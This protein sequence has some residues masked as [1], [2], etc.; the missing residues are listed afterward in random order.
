MRRGGG[1]QHGKA[2]IADRQ[3]LLF[4]PFK[5]PICN[6]QP[7]RDELESGGI[8]GREEPALNIL[9]SSSKN[10]NINNN[11]KTASWMQLIFKSAIL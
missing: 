7:P 6:D 1:K 9:L 3:L 5:S 2:L 11:K 4:T 10:N 8:G